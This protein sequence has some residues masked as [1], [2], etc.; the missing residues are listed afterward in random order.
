MEHLLFAAFLIFFA[1][2]VTKVG[3]FRKSGLTNSQLVILFLLKVMAGIFYGWIGVYYGEM[4]QMIDTWAY[5]QESL[6]EYELLLSNPAEFFFSSFRSHYDN[7]YAQFLS[8][9]NSWWNDIK[10][11]FLI[12]LMALFN[13]FSFVNYY[14]NVIFY[15]FLNL[16]GPIA[17]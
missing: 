13:V 12:K 16:F 11:L 6:Q 3:F 4:A 1:W 2:L 7:G 10:G 17:L 5:H 9:E 8:T 15:C 14:N